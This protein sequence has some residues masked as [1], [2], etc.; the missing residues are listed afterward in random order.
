MNLNEPLLDYCER[1]GPGLLAEPLNAFSNGAFLVAALYLWRGGGAEPGPVAAAR[2]WLA[3]LLALV[4]LGSLAF[5]TLATR[6]TSIL[7]VACIGIFNLAYLLLFVRLVARR[8]W[9]W[10]LGAALAFIV[11]DRLAGAVLPSSAVNGSLL[12][13]PALLVLSGLTAYALRRAPPAGR[14]MLGAAAAFWLSL[15]LR[16]LDRA[17]CPVWPWGTHFAWHLLNAWV[18]Y[19]LSAALLHGARRA[20][21]PGGREPGAA[22]AR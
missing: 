20:A 18:L 10:A 16:S 9:P 1:L 7:D 22:A 8:P 13:A 14:L 3:S 6:G 4:G 11:V 19:R 5:H 15:V 17:L 21:G 2:V 12:Y